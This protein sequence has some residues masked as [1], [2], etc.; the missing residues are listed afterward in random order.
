LLKTAGYCTSLSI[1]VTFCRILSIN[2]KVS[3][4]YLFIIDQNG[5]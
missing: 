2:V 3:L 5:L 1:L 4:Y